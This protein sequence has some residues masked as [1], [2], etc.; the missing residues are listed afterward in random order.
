[1]EQYVN[2]HGRQPFKDVLNL[3]VLGE[4]PLVGFLH[5]SSSTLQLLV[6]LVRLAVLTHRN[7]VTQGS[8]CNLL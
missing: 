8:D 3:D 5:Y 2:Y 4:S 6:G 7:A 1:M